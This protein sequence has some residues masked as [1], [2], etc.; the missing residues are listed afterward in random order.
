MIVGML[1]IILFLAAYF[2]VSGNFCSRS[3][4]KI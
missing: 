3:E 2:S 1:D 4:A